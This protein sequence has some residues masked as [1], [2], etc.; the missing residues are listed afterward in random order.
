MLPTGG[1]VAGLVGLSV[2][3][4][5]FHRVVPFQDE[6]FRPVLAPPFEVLLPNAFECVVEDVVDVVGPDAVEAEYERVDFRADEGSL[7]AAVGA[8]ARSCELSRGSGAPDP[9]THYQQLTS[10]K[11]PGPRFSAAARTSPRFVQIRVQLLG[12]T[13]NTATVGLRSLSCR[14]SRS[15]VISRLYPAF[16]A[17]RRRSPFSNLSQPSAPAASMLCSGKNVATCIGVQWSRSMIFTPL[18]PLRADRAAPGARFPPAIA[19]LPD[20]IRGTRRWMRH[21]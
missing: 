12:S 21:R 18:E 10:S 15:L 11:S 13:S 2:S 7:T 4:G 14:K 9:R 8:G 17:E 20:T 6:P 5:L 1:L 3:A 19:P 16:S